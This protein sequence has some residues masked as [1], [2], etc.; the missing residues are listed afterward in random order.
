MRRRH[1]RWVLAL[2]SACGARSEIEEFTSDTRGAGGAVSAGAIAA[3]GSPSA[4]AG[5]IAAAGAPSTAGPSG[6]HGCIAFTGT[7]IDDIE[8]RQSTK[9]LGPGLQLTWSSTV[10][11]EPG[12]QLK[13]AQLAPPRGSSRF[14]MHGRTSG[15]AMSVGFTLRPCADLGGV[16]GIAFWARGNQSLK[17]SVNLSTLTSTPVLLGGLCDWPACGYPALVVVVTNEWQ[18]FELLFDSLEPAYPPADFQAFTGLELVSGASSGP[19]EL[20]VDDPEVLR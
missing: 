19:V 18:R 7:L 17:T 9:S 1:L 2:L 3:G 15:P 11:L 20:W 6:P 5:A 4:S 10:T 8:D 13:A 16:R 14:A 12:L